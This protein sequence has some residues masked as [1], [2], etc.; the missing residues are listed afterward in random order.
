MRYAILELKNQIEDLENNLNN[1]N[2][3]SNGNVIITGFKAI[4]SNLVG[5]YQNLSKSDFNR[6]NKY[7]KQ[8]K[9]ILNSLVKVDQKICG[10]MGVNDSASMLMGQRENFKNLKKVLTF[11]EKASLMEVY[12]CKYFQK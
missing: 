2:E 1:L 6:K 5:V 7:M 9:S 11:I 10:E 8:L 12:Q 3:M 4:M